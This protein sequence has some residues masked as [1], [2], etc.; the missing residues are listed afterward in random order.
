MDV[1][2]IATSYAAFGGVLVG[3]AFAGLSIYVNRSSGSGAHGA[4]V[5]VL[6]TRRGKPIH[7][8]LIEVSAVA[9]TGFYAMASLGISTF[10]YAN[11]SGTAS[12][13]STAI[14]SGKASDATAAS[15]EA[16][17][18]V[19]GVAFGLSVLT[20]FYFMTLM[21]FEN[22]FTRRAAKPAFWAG[23]I[24]GSIVV[25]RFLAGT[26]QEAQLAQCPSNHPL[27]YPGAPYTT[28]GITITLLAEAMVFVVI[29]LTRVLEC[30]PFR[31]LLAPLA[32]RPSLP[33]AGV[34]L[35]S[36]V[37][38]TLASLYLNALT[39]PP[40]HWFISGSYL[41]GIILIV[42]FALASGSVIYPRI[43]GIRLIG[44]AESQ[45]AAAHAFWW[46]RIR[47]WQVAQNNT[48]YIEY[49][50][51]SRP[52]AENGN[53]MWKVP[54]KSCELDTRFRVW[55]N[56]S[57]WH[58]GGRLFVADSGKRAS[59]RQA[60]SVN[61]TLNTGSGTEMRVIGTYTLKGASELRLDG[62]EQ[63][64]ASDVLQVAIRRL[65]SAEDDVLLCWLEAGGTID[66]PRHERRPL[67]ADES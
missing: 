26:A 56:K 8:P 59:P 16:A 14:L 4:A 49:T 46:R 9:A 40:P 65:D 2:S 18:L 53:I 44:S 32:H 36:V 63:P 10:L 25:L 7:I 42:L 39:K 66:R 23:T 28:L 62:H 6:I 3:F 21:L 5:D 35:T 50:S 22:S 45:Q 13:S 61:V 60:Y 41:I 48:A 52:I 20:L 38:A 67:I 57:P 47:A 58:L 34:F 55:H 64:S 33:S 31:W 27:C 43:H 19:Y 24:V 1:S 11:L 54:K 17:L 29:T 51:G 37:V 30:K 15:A 12:P